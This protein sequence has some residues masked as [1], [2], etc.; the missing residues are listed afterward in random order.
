M[1]I[2]ELR[3]EVVSA[4][5]ARDYARSIVEAV[6]VPLV[7]LDAGLRVLSANAAYYHLFQEEPTATEGHGFFELGGGEWDTA[8]L[9]GAVAALL[10]AAGRFQ[11]LAL[12]REFPGAG[13]RATSV[14]GC[15]VPSPGS[16]PLILLAIEDVTE[17][18][19]SERH[20]AE[21]LAL[22]EEAQERAE[23]AD[24]AKDLFLAHLSHELRNPLSAILLHAQALQTSRLDA[25]GVE[26]AGVAIEANTKR[27][28]KLVEDLLDVS[29][30]VAGKL[31]L[32]VEEVDWRALVLGVLEA[33]KPA[34]AA[35][36]V[37]LATELEGEPPLCLGDPGRLQ[38]VVAN[39]LTN[40]VEFTPS[41][42]RVGVQVDA[43]DGMARLVVTDTGRGI[44]PA[45]L[46]HVFERFAQEEGSASHGSGLGLGLAIV[47]Q[48][49]ALHGGTVRAESPG[50]DLGA[51]FTVTLPRQ[52]TT[53]GSVA[54]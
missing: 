41:G 44:A 4:R 28:V 11:A 50:R 25:H 43:V 9:H 32:A 18:R 13:H 45:L 7:V 6:Q 26:C 22:A 29:R 24:A 15:A 37:Q 14:S 1:D 31:S 48:L 53:P 47:H 54:G 49:V 51:T 46:P 23:R 35:K 39:L 2:D 34:A 38:Q 21:L 30:I 27:Q 42:G 40:A 52:P 16:E 17:Q 20:R 5:W 36:S 33:V 19:R 8:E 3:H 10:G 12:E